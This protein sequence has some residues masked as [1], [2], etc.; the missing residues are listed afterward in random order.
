MMLQRQATKV[1][2]DYIENFGGDWT[3]V[4]AEVLRDVEWLF[5]Y[6]TEGAKLYAY[7]L[8]D[9]YHELKPKGTP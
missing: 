2:N 4:R 1:I 5:R 6:N 8:D 3:K 7:A 9:I